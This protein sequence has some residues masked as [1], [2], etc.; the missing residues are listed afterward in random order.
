MNVGEQLRAFRQFL[1]QSWP[2]ANEVLAGKENLL[3][4]WK[5]ANWEILVEA[6]LV[7][8]REF[9]EVYGDGADCN[10]SSSR[11]WKPT[12]LNTHAVH[13]VPIH[14]PD[15]VDQ[16]RGTKFSCPSQGLPM[17]QF[18]TLSEAGWYEPEPPFGHVLA[19]DGDHEKVLL[20]EDVDF[21]LVKASD[22]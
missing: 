6:V 1:N 4:D 2:I 12:A 13:V 15:M 3:D 16:L 17:D 11:V 9:L 21:I 22:S 18:V 20:V 8:S 5:Q 19:V 7:N 10:G 14:G